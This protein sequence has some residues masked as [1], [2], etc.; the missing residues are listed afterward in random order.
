MQKLPSK[1]LYKCKLSL[2]YFAFITFSSTGFKQVY[3]FQYPS[4]FGHVDL[5]S[6]ARTDSITGLI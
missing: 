1:K 6:G 4:E 2:N 3:P 5:K